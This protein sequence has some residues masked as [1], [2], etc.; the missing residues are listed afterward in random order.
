V[1][2]RGAL[3]GGYYDHNLS[4]IRTANNLNKADTKIAELKA[5]ID[6]TRKNLQS[7]IYKYHDYHYHY[8]ALIIIIIIIYLIES[9]RN[10]SHGFCLS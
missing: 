3:T 2:K 6:Q 7:L 5:K 1:N 8:Y 4:R 9:N 10:N